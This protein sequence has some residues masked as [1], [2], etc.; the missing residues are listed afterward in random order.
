MPVLA[1]AYRFV[2]EYAGY[3]EIFLDYMLI[4]GIVVV[5]VLVV[6]LLKQKG[7]NQ[8]NANTKSANKHANLRAQD[9]AE[10]EPETD[11]WEVQ[12]EAPSDGLNY[13]DRKSVV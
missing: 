12:A 13:Q 6:V 4:I 10:D 8:S 9:E 7:A 2:F 3:W 11:E 5:V 1:D